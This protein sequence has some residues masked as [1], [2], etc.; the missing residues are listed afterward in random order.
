M[1]RFQPGQ[2][3]NPAGR[4]PRSKALNEILRKYSEGEIELGDT[5]VQRKEALAQM[6]WALVLDGKTKYTSGRKVLRVEDVNDWMK[7]VEFLFNRIDGKPV[8]QH[9]LSGPDGGP[10]ESSTVSDLSK[11]SVAELKQLRDLAEKMESE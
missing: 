6:A 2:S 1:A 9:E 7:I 3:G 5:K 10:I 11:L 4:P 8:S